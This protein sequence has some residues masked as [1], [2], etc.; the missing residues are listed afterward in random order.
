VKE[1]FGT[2]ERGGEQQ[3]RLCGKVGQKCGRRERKREKRKTQLDCFPPTPDGAGL[4]NDL[5]KA[6]LR[7]AEPW[8]GAK[9]I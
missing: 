5:L 6:V 4:G 2:V 1:S 3:E 9:W 7:L 8:M